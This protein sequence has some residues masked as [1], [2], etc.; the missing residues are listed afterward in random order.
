MQILNTENLFI[1][2]VCVHMKKLCDA[3]TE[4]FRNMKK[5]DLII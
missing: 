3:F 5:Y 1:W 4:L 2:S